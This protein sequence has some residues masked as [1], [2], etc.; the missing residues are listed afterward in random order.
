MPGPGRASAEDLLER[1]REGVR[2]PA[3][4]RV[5]KPADERRSLYVRIAAA[6]GRSHNWD[7]SALVVE[8]AEREGRAE[9]EIVGAPG[10]DVRG[11]ILRAV[12][13]RA[14]RWGSLRRATGVTT[15]A[16]RQAVAGARRTTPSAAR[17][18]ATSVARSARSATRCIALRSSIVNPL[19]RC[20]RPRRRLASN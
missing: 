19:P 8:R 11:L 2:Q 18:M 20:H 9:S 10:S 1:P 15:G 13:I 4:V 12:A 17:A 3:G 6:T 14:A 7:G 5:C 16:T